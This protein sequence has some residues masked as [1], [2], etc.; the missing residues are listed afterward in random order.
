MIQKK[1]LFCEGMYESELLSL[2]S[3]VL[4]L[5]GWKGLM[6]VEICEIKQ[7]NTGD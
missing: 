3:I 7:L 4:L 2:I 1:S 6:L 5:K